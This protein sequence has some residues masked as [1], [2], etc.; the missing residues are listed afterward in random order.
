[1]TSTPNEPG[2]GGYSLRSIRDEYHRDLFEDY[3][4]FWDRHGIDH[5]LGGFICALDHDGTRI[6]TDKFMW[7]QGRGLWVYSHLY[8]C[9]GDEAHL[10]VARRTAEFLLKHGRDDNG[11]WALNLDRSGNILT[12]ASPRGY[13]GMFVA[14]GLQE[15]AR[16]TSNAAMMDLAIDALWRA[17]ERWDDPDCNAEEFYIPL[18]YPGMRT[19]GSHMVAIRI[20]TQTLAWVSDPKLEALADRMVDAIINRFWNP[21]YRLMNEA[22][23]H[24]YDRP[25]DANED[26]VYLGHAIEALWMVLFEAMRRKDKELF[27]T[28]SERE[29]Y[30][31]LPT[32]KTKNEGG[33]FGR[34]IFQGFRVSHFEMSGRSM[35]GIAL[36]FSIWR[37]LSSSLRKSTRR[38]STFDCTVLS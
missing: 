37:S 12:P 17:M 21:E 34:A 14:E 20:L 25:A 8:N 31:I 3:L 11:E 28:T 27:D 38:L 13:E 33:F 26:F 2:I 6:N 15:Y 5:E 22:L 10:E 35:A 32:A 24:N 9:F 7:Y 23:D 18:S 16:A 30:T 1:M 4:P 19:L 36:R 29:L